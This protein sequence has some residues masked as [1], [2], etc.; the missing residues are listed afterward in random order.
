M[1]TFRVAAIPSPL[2]SF[3]PRRREASGSFDVEQRPV[4]ARESHASRD[5][6]LCTLRAS[7]RAR[8][9]PG[10][11][12]PSRM[13]AMGCREAGTLQDGCFPLGGA[14]K[15]SDRKTAQEPCGRPGA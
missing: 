8:G 14:G 15:G 3:L 2:T 9:L 1:S 5:F 10:F 13:L 7:F 6:G 12:N 11:P 4:A